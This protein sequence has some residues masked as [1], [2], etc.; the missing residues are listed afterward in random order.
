MV[1]PGSNAPSSCCL[2]SWL[3]VEGNSSPGKTKSALRPTFQATGRTGSSPEQMVLDASHLREARVRR[4]PRPERQSGS[5]ENRVYNH[6]EALDVGSGYDRRE[7]RKASGRGRSHFLQERGSFTFDP[8]R[9]RRDCRR[10][11]SATTVLRSAGSNPG[12]ILPTARS[13]LSISILS[14]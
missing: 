3:A 5:S 14:R 6:C 2:N 1:I 10:C 12:A 7:P 13:A 4:Y 8:A 9:A 11:E